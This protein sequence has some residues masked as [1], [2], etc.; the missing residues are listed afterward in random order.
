MR[1]TDIVELLR[2]EA[3]ATEEL[4]PDDSEIEVMRNA[5][6]EIERLRCICNE[7]I[8]RCAKVADNKEYEWTRQWRAGHKADSHLEGM[9]DGAGEVATAIRGLVE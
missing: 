7:S 6:N 2:L 5:A 4:H 3:N 1:P 8:E 9:S